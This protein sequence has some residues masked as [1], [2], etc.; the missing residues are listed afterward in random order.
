VLDATTILSY[1][2]HLPTI[3]CDIVGR[4]CYGYWHQKRL[5]FKSSK[6]ISKVLLDQ[7]AIFSC[8]LFSDAVSSS[9]YVP[10][11]VESG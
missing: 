3:I 1:L 11:Y 9:D 8:S 6:S 5:Q 2:A 7:I 10:L 4:V